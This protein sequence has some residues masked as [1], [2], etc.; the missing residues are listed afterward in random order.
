MEVTA[1]QGSAVEDKGTVNE[2]ASLVLEGFT[3]INVENTS[4]GTL[5]LLVPCCETAN[6]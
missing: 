3:I 1:Y 4:R 2:S 6:S 5:L